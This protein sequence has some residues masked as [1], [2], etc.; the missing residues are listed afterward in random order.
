VDIGAVA[1]S[2]GALPVLAAGQ[3][4]FSEIP[5]LCKPEVVLESL[6]RMRG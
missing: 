4:Y 2:E 3:F 5:V 6:A 1:W